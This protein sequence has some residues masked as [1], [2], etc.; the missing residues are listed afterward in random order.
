M[1]E[2]GGYR[3]FV[4][5]IED[6]RKGVKIVVYTQSAKLIYSLLQS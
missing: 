3:D 2:G 4:V 6:G 5:R 1:C